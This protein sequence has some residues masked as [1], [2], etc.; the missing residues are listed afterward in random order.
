MKKVLCLLLCTLLVIYLTGCHE[1]NQAYAV[2]P[3]KRTDGAVN[4]QIIDGFL[5]D[6]DDYSNYEA[7]K[8]NKPDILSHLVNITPE[9][10]REKCSIYRFSYESDTSLAGE[11]FL[12][13]DDAVYPLGC[14]LGGYGI[15]E[16]AYSSDNGND[17]LYFIYS[18]GSG[19]HRSHIGLFDFESKE[20]FDY[21]GFIFLDQ[22]IAFYLSEDGKTLGICQAQICWTDWDIIEMTIDKGECL[23]DDI[24]TFDFSAIDE[25][26]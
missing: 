16:F 18:W 11:T 4:K 22:D 10:L 5:T 3:M 23:C 17:I 15:T 7:I 9:V 25:R 1:A 19:I 12:I 20:I 6:N 2:L 14:A 21:G 8:K 26:E 13:Y 24:S